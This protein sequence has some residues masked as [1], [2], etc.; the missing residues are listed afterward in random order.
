MKLF[1]I[2]YLPVLI[3][4][5]IFHYT[6][7]IIRNKLYDYKIFKTY[8]YNDTTIISIGNLKLGGTGKTPLVEYLIN[9]LPNSKIA[10]LSRG[11]KRKTNGF[12]VAKKKSL[13][14]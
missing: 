14:I 11:Y 12:L 6:I 4:L 7:L 10:I 3:I 13:C 9:I 2:V 1:K 8:Y 5:Y